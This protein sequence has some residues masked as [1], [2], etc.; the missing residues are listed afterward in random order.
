M[1]RTRD[2]LGVTTYERDTSE[3]PENDHE[4]PPVKKVNVGYRL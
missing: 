2:I 3:I 1:L 4:S